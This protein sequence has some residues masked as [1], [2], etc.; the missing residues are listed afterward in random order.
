[1]VITLSKVMRPN[2]Q[3]SILQQTEGSYFKRKK[4]DSLF[5]KV[6]ILILANHLEIGITT[7]LLLDR[8]LSSGHI[9]DADVKLFFN[10]VRLFYETTFEYALKRLPINDPFLKNAQVIKF[11]ARASD[12]TEIKQP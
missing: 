7:R 4:K 12:S 5:W 1:M 10:G 11:D 9:T 2:L 3:K 6:V 8:L